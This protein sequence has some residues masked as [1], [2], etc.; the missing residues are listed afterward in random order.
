MSKGTS[1]SRI[2]PSRFVK[3]LK[4]VGQ[5]EPDLARPPSARLPHESLPLGRLQTV[6]YD[7][8]PSNESERIPANRLQNHGARRM[9]I[10]KKKLIRASAESHGHR[11][12]GT[13][14][15]SP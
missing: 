15:V 3:L 12:V 5:G 1:S 9:A 11:G 13:E 2:T 6:A 10:S 7:V 4:L 14:A 8:L